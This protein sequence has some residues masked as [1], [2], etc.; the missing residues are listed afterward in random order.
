MNNPKVVEENK[1]SRQE[2]IKELGLSQEQIEK[3][4]KLIAN[5]DESKAKELGEK[6]V[7]FICK[8]NYNEEDDATFQE[9]LTL[10]KDGADLNF[11][12]SKGN[13]P[14]LQCA[15]KNYQKTFITL[16][17]FGADIFKVNKNDTNVVMSSAR[18][19][20]YTIL[21]ISILMG[22][23]VN[24]LCNDNDTA[25]I[26]A[27]RHGQ[28][29]CFDTLIKN[30]A[31][32]NIKNYLNLT[33]YDIQNTDGGVNIDDSKYYVK[34]PTNPA[35]QVLHEDAMDLILA[36]TSDLCDFRE[37][38]PIQTS[39]ELP[40]TTESDNKST[41]SFAEELQGNI[42]INFKVR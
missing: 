33:S 42:N 6:L 26:M 30:N 25:L 15:R 16:L 39:E 9:V 10:I 31:I 21:G 41:I 13:F 20:N 4:R 11:E 34:V 23:P 14:L 40:D 29:L 2:R 8:K 5:V 17:K 27:K 22:V 18:N 28:K 1:R 32:L 12:T 38:L 37:T 36:A 35:S 19:G 3:N 7:K 24:D